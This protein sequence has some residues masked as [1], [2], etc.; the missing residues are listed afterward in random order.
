MIFVGQIYFMVHG[1]AMFYFP[2]T[3]RSGYFSDHEPLNKSGDE[4]HRRIYA[5]VFISVIETYSFHIL[6]E[7][8]RDDYDKR[9][10]LP[11]YLFPILR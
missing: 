5:F 6:R 10:V 2:S 1:N 11:D 9:H 3:Q 7:Y 4:L 8:V